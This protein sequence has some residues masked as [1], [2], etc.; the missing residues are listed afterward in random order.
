MIILKNSEGL[1]FKDF[2]SVKFLTVLIMDH[3]MMLSNSI[4][5]IYGQL[6]AT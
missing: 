4:P 3:A 6:S 5:E 1:D 2:E